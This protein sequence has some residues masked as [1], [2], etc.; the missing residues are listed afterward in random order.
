MGPSTVRGVVMFLFKDYFGILPDFFLDLSSTMKIVHA[1]LLFI[2]QAATKSKGARATASAADDMK[3]DD[4]EDIES[5]RKSEH[6]DSEDETEGSDEELA[7]AAPK[8]SRGSWEDTPPFGCTDG[9]QQ[10]PSP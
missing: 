8:G 1:F 2:F 9:F 6:D 7:G 10:L 5:D 4:E 3:D